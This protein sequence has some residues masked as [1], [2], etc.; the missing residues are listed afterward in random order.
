MRALCLP[1]GRIFRAPNDSQ[2]RELGALILEPNAVRA[3]LATH[4]YVSEDPED[5]VGRVETAYQMLLRVEKPFLALQ[6]AWSKGELDAETL[7]EALQAA[8]D[9]QVIRSEDV[10]PLR[11]YDARRRDCVLT[12]HFET[13]L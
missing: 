1:L 2:I 9:K 12:D 11:E 6:R 10:E 8:V 7:D 5:A 13:L 3:M 4:V